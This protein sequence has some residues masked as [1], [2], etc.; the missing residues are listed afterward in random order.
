MTGNE[1]ALMWTDPIFMHRYALWS[2]DVEEGLVKAG[3]NPWKSAQL[4]DRLHRSL[5]LVVRKLNNQG[6]QQTNRV[7]GWK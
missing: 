7:A 3:E 4:S 5:N 6:N 1:S 2:G